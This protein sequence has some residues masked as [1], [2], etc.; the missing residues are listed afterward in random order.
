MENGYK[1][2]VLLVTYNHEKYIKEAIESILMQNFKY[3]YEIVVVDDCST[4]GSL[5]ILYEYKKIYGDKINI[6][7][8]EKNLGITKNY[9]RGFEEC[10]GEYIAVL[11]GDDYWTS[12]LNLQKHVDFLD[13][14][15][16]CVLSFN[17]FVVDDIKSKRQNIQPWPI[18]DKYQLVT[19]ADLARDNFIGNFSTCVYRANIVKKIDNSLY[20]I[21]VY[22]GMF[23]IV[24]AHNGLIAYLPEVMS[25]YRLHPSG[26]WTQKT[27]V[28]KLENTI[29]YIEVYNKYL[30]FV[31]NAEFTEH[32]DRLCSRIEQLINPDGSYKVPSMKDEI[33]KYIPPIIIKILK[34]IL[35]PKLIE[36]L[37]R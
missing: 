11:E 2:S 15:K 18:N 4:D 26:V 31:Y 10:K 25:V 14:H 9:Q 13:E 6:L 35:P 7:R 8:N 29:E 30:D 27:E 20:N 5:Q 16:E 36:I 24:M 37:K 19:A 1:L 21:V 23:N 22:D 32:K 33:K 17:R 34:L 28:D 3:D 12:P